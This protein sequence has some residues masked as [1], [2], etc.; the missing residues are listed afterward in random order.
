MTDYVVLVE[1]GDSGWGAWSPD[2]DVYATASTRDLVEQQVQEAIAFHLEGS[3][4]SGPPLGSRPSR[5]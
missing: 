1:R 3:G 4:R 5:R 2:L